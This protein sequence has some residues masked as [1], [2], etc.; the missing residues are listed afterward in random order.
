MPTI[1]DPDALAL[2]YSLNDLVIPEDVH[3]IIAF[4]LEACEAEGRTFRNSLALAGT[5]GAGK[6]T[7]MLA[8]ARQIA[9]T[10]VVLV[11]SKPTA[12]EVELIKEAI[13]DGCVLMLDEVHDYANQAWL[14]DTTYGARGL[15]RDGKRID[16]TVF[17]ATTNRGA[18][19]QTL[20]SRFPI[21][22]NLRY[23]R[24]EVVQIL[25]QVAKRFSVDLDDDGR[26]VLYNAANGNPRTAETVLG[27][28]GCGDPREAVKMAQL[29]PD[30]LDHDCLRLLAYLEEHRSQR[31]AFGR[32]TLAKALESPGGIADIEAILI[33][34]RYIIHT[35]QGLEISSNGVKRVQRY[36]QEVGAVT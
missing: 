17:A 21:K 34:R 29:E 6:T 25:D 11:A 30:G 8:I 20:F 3:E 19:P 10:R 36:M 31:K 26:K 22:L 2:E 23:S 18:L 33:R 7:L 28:W 14:L 1:L 15:I 9:A 24:E 32:N 27:F 13:I 35:P 16:F 5:G 12:K 4:E